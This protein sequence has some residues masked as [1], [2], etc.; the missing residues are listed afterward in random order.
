MMCTPFS[1]SDSIKELA[2]GRSITLGLVTVL[3]I[4]AVVLFIAGLLV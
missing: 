3:C 1:L 2:E 4:M